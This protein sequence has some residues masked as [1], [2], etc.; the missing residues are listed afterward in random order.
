MSYPGGKAGD[1]VY[2]RLISLMP[3]HDVYIEPFVGGGAL[4]CRKRPARLNIGVDLDAEVIRQWQ[5]RTARAS[6]TA[7]GIA[8][9][10]KA[11]FTFHVGDGLAF[12]Q[13][14]PFTGREL[15]YCDP[16]YVLRTRTSRQYRYEM[17]D[18]QHAA[19][20]AILT[21][22]PCA[23]MLSGYWTAMYAEALDGWTTI[24]YEAMTR[25]GRVATEWLWMNYPRPLHLHDYRYLG[26][27]FRE[28]ERI[29]RKK[30]R[31]VNRLQT[32]PHLERQALLSAVAEAF[33][34]PAA[35]AS[36]G[37]G[38]NPSSPRQP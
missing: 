6:D 2:Q 5:A 18:A 12:L 33:P 32:M 9:H 7:G 36:H 23:V 20:L 10:D 14:Y 31:W 15:V 29:R 38:D 24:T 3:P 21:T 26:E 37:E 19:L 13:S 25:G 27:G 34:S 30:Q 35:L 17:T 4:L 1:G 22:L 8:T 11:K 28:R 16:P